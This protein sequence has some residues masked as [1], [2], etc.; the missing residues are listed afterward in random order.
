MGGD[1]ARGG[2]GVKAADL[3]RSLQR[4][5]VWL[6]MAAPAFAPLWPILT[7]AWAWIGRAGSP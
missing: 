6:G 2:R 3:L 5:A 4:A 1:T 7:P